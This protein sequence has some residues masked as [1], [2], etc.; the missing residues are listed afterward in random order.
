MAVD[1][2]RSLISPGSV[3]GAP[4]AIDTRKATTRVIV[5]NGQ[6]T[7]IGGVY[8][9]DTSTTTTGV[10]WLKDLPIVGGMFR[11][12]EN[13]SA[14]N[15]LMIFITPRIISVAKEFDNQLMGE[16]KVSR[17]EGVSSEN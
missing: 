9:N 1:V 14:R 10:P 2:E 13:R 3:S 12:R 17:A 8:Q 5:K 15:E 6:T 7:I 11:T 16:K 4:P